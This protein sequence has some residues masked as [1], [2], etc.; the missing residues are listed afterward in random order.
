M[1]ELS[2]VIVIGETSENQ[3][4]QDLLSHI[5]DG[6]ASMVKFDSLNANKLLTS[7]VG[8]EL[9]SDHGAKFSSS[10]VNIVVLPNAT[11]ERV[12]SEVENAFNSVPKE[13]LLVYSGLICQS[14]ANWILSDG[15]L[16]P[17][18][19]TDR[20][21]AASLKLQQTL[22][23]TTLEYTPALS[24]HVACTSVPHGGDWRRVLSARLPSSIAG[25]PLCLTV[26]R[27]YAP[28]KKPAS[29][30]I[31]STKTEFAP[32]PADI[33]GVCS[34]CQRLESVIELSKS[35]QPTFQPVSKASDCSIQ[36]RRPCL[37][38]F[39]EGSGQ[40]SIFALPGFTLMVNAGASRDPKCWKLAQHFENID[41]ILQ[42]HWGV[43]N[44]LGLTSLLP[45]LIS[46]NDDSSIQPNTTLV[47]TAP[48]VHAITHPLPAEISASSD[49]LVMNVA[50]V[51]SELASTVKSFVADGKLTAQEVTRGGKITAMPK[52]ICLYYKV[53]C[54]SLDFYPLTPTEE[55]HAEIK[56]LTTL[57]AKAAPNVA[58]ALAEAPRGTSAIKHTTLP[59]VSQLSVSGLLIW[60]SHR[61]GDRHV[62]ILFVAPNAH[63][64]RVLTALE[65]L[66]LGF[67][68]IRSADPEGVFW[69]AA[70]AGNAFGG[71][72][73]SNSA[74]PGARNISRPPASAKSAVSTTRVP[75]STSKSMSIRNATA[76]SA[77]HTNVRLT[78]PASKTKGPVK[79]MEQETKALKHESPKEAPKAEKRKDE[80]VEPSPVPSDSA[81]DTISIMQTKISKPSSYSDEIP[82]SALYY[83]GLKLNSNAY[84]ELL[85]IAV[86]QLSVSGLLIWKSHRKGD[87]HVRILFVAPNAHQLRVLTA[88][89]ALHLGF[90]CIRSADPEGVFWNAASAGNAF[91]GGRKS[92]SAVPGAR[93]IS[94]PPAS[95]KSAVSTTRVPLSTSK[96]MSIRNATA[97][98]AAHTNVRLTK[99]ASKTKGP[100]KSMEQETKAL[101]HESPKEAPKAE[102]RKD[103]VVEPSPVPSGEISQA[104]TIELPPEGNPVSSKPEFAED[105]NGGDNA[106]QTQGSYAKCP[107]NEEELLVDGDQHI[108]AE[109][110]EVVEL[111]LVTPGEYINPLEDWGQPQAM[112]A[113][114]GEISQAPTIE[115]PPEGNPVSSKP[116]F[117]EDLNG[118]DNAHQTQGS[119]AKCPLN[120]EE[121]LVDGDQRIPAEHPEVVELPL[122]TPGEY[123]N[124]LEDWGQPQAMPAPI[125]NVL[126]STSSAKT[127]PAVQSPPEGY[128]EAS[129]GAIKGLIDKMTKRT[130]VDVAFLPGGGDTHLVDAEFFKRVSA[131]YYIATTAAP[132]ADL[133]KAM[134]T[135]KKTFGGDNTEGGNR[136][137]SLILARDSPCLLEWAALNE[138]RLVDAKIDLLTV[139]ER[140]TIQ[141]MTAEGTGNGDISCPGFRL[142]F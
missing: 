116:E 42:T 100:V 63:Q 87:R 139:A 113:P 107:L 46:S 111:P 108:P 31:A 86:S 26:N 101:K 48:P 69:N 136:E 105:L 121:L 140:S 126:K 52:P 36:I 10:E 9:L 106:H 17:D 114:I 7:V 37:Y 44:C 124:P 130:F 103:E 66:H 104:P 40:S 1:S 109:H 49:L 28:I 62:R 91:G 135:G 47:L 12:L 117:A 83:E 127:A 84:V 20:I 23:D 22:A 19:V 128:Y 74:V 11:I 53:G 4:L 34:F 142:D 90:P 18:Y 78:K 73:K 35:P 134:V 98:S 61:K 75:L 14:S 30:V 71:G 94:R 56:K 21:S 39:P 125:A 45:A 32:L 138:K 27:L 41:A 95:A 67:P 54:G 141:V 33:S 70:S 132:T 50:H 65:A 2:V 8:P 15:V 5:K 25:H 16:K 29:G 93:N 24:F 112:P 60:K 79:S 81:V 80:V 122:V 68:C 115:L 137:V 133:L 59:L 55:D 131:R 6:I 99:P 85:T 102:K 97:S 57:W 72:R 58:S 38:I 123:I 119:Y 120:E 88:L 13:V 51:A 3:D 110:P 76:S 96:S 64:L 118:G 92:N 82:P 129:A 77:A 89:E 43:E